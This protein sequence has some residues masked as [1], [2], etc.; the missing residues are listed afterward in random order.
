MFNINN[1]KENRIIVIGDLMLDYYLNGDCNRISGEAPVQIV[2]IKETNKTLGGSGNVA[3]NL[4]S[5]GLKVSIFSVIGN[6]NPGKDILN[7]LKNKEIDISNIRID[8]KRI[9]TQKSRVLSRGQQIIRFDNEI[10]DPIDIEIA[11]DWLK[12]IEKLFVNDNYEAVILSDYA[13]GVLTDYFLSEVIKLCNAHK[14]IIL[15]DPK[16]VDFLKYK[17]C[18]AITPNKK[19]A[20]EASGVLIKDKKSLEKAAKIIFKQCKLKFLIITLSED[21]I[22]LFENDTL[23]IFQTQASDVYD[24]SG[25]GDTV[26]ASILF[27]IINKLSLRDSCIFSNVAAGYVVSQIGTASVTLSQ[28]DS[29]FQNRVLSFSKKIL[30]SETLLCKI[31][32]L[33]SKGKRIVFTNGCFDII[34]SGHVRYLE[35]A[36]SLGDILVVA[37]NSDESVKR[38]KGSERPIVKQSDRSIVLSGLESVDFVVV[39]DADNPL[40]IIKDISPHVLVKGSDYDINQVIGADF[41]EKNG[42]KTVLIDFYENKSTSN[43]INKIKSM[44]YK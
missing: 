8:K 12:S 30:N 39:F 26:I 37:I 5:L 1:T 16:G 42:G 14:K 41:L 32:D 24:V 18:T 23:E 25:A 13:K 34:H 19:E 35:K 21:G 36:A 44:N 28:I 15:C 31:K 2:N 20:S 33:K 29:F 4:N 9:T 27:G 11:D 40:E 43:I 22:A 7:L 10:N 17:N 38:L 6:D 3:A